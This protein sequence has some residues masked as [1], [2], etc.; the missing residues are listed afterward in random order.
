MRTTQDRVK[1]TRLY[2]M[3]SGKWVAGNVIRVH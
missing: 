2:M 1:K 3:K